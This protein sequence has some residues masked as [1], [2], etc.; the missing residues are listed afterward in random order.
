LSKQLLFPV[1][2]FRAKFETAR[3]KQLSPSNKTVKNMLV[4]THIDRQA[5]H[6][7]T[8]S[9]RTVRDPFTHREGKYQSNADQN[10]SLADKVVKP[11]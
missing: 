5:Y 4:V 2:T 7:S 11:T 3:I 8:I 6:S 10:T 1:V 9:T